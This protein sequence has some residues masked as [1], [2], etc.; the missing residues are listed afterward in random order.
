MNTWSFDVSQLRE[1]RRFT[2][3]SFHCKHE[4]RKSVKMIKSKILFSFFSFR[5]LLLLEQLDGTNRSLM[6]VGT[7]A[8]YDNSK[9][10]LRK[11][12]IAQCK[13]DYVIQALK[14]SLICSL[15]WDRYIIIFSICKLLK[16]QPLKQPVSVCSVLFSWLSHARPAQW[17][18]QRL[19]ASVKSPDCSCDQPPAWT[20]A[21]SL[22]I[23]SSGYMEGS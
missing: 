13:K 5:L 16:L 12:S 18:C 21:A 3:E 8:L 2:E 19:P 15:T 14:D 1:L 17:H 22:L 9:Y 6:L 7:S 11:M 23:S 20:A 4:G 10:M